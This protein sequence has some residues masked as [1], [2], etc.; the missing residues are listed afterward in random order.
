M[1]SGTG[2]VLW[3]QRRFFM[4]RG[5]GYE[6]SNQTT[7]QEWS[8]IPHWEECLLRHALPAASLPQWWRYSKPLLYDLLPVPLSHDHCWLQKSFFSI[9]ACQKPTDK[10][11][12]NQEPQQ[13]SARC[14]RGREDCEVNS[15][16]GWVRSA[17]IFPVKARHIVR[18]KDQQNTRQILVKYRI[19]TSKILAIYR[20]SAPGKPQ[21]L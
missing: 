5:V 7:E 17:R 14:Y 12:E 1:I 19:N 21:V 15:I 4:A 13:C 3:C 2:T 11:V 9:E 16:F 20:D 6:A 8:Y 10:P 18:E